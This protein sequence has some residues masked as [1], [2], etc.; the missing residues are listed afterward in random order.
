M[1]LM[2]LVKEREILNKFQVLLKYGYDATNKL[3]KGEGGAQCNAIIY[4]AIL[5]LPYKYMKHSNQ[6][7]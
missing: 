3:K 1:A 4:Y 5:S 7:F 6:V 2:L